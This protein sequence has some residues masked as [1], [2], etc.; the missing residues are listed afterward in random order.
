MPSPFFGSVDHALSSEPSP[1]LC[2][3]W[4]PY[5]TIPS[6]ILLLVWVC[7]P[8]CSQHQSAVL[9]M[10]A[11]TDRP[12]GGRDSGA[13]PGVAGP[14]AT[15]VFRPPRPTG[16]KPAG[17]GGGMTARSSRN[18]AGQQDDK[19]FHLGRNPTETKNRRR[20][21]SLKRRFPLPPLT[22]DPQGNIRS[23]DKAPRPVRRSHMAFMRCRPPLP[24]PQLF[25][26]DT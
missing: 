23:G 19:L 25:G 12:S 7:R 21:P 10:E 4:S 9:K 11:T 17:G 16:P 3:V 8:A 14:S 18:L 15:A 26:V 5:R 2:S 1:L 24:R 20:C 6:A 22:A 13:I